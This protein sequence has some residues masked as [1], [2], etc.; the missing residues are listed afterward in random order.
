MNGITHRQAGA[1]AI[2]AV[3]VPFLV[4]LVACEGPAHVSSPASGAVAPAPDALSPYLP[5]AADLQVI[6]QGLHSAVDDCLRSVGLPR[7]TALSVHPSPALQSD[8]S[9]ITISGSLPV[10]RAQQYGYIPVAV[11][12]APLLALD[13]GWAVTY[14]IPR[15]QGSELSITR[16][17]LLGKVARVDGRA[18]PDGGC[19]AKAIE[20]VTG[21]PYSAVQASND[22]DALPLILLR[23][24][25]DQVSRDSPVKAV[26]VR[27]ATCIRQAGYDYAT[28]TA[29]QTDPRWLRVAA[30]GASEKSLIA[31][32]V[33][34]AVADARCRAEVGYASARLAAFT[35]A[36]S[37]LVARD[38][39][40]RALTRF[41]ADVTTAVA[42]ARKLAAR[43]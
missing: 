29:A 1:A 36:L 34:V 3:L 8:T 13:S 33:P 22:I 30:A 38:G 16:A 18:V 23:Q 21:D 35:S 4:F 26:T 2:L 39:I 9:L 41:D 20:Q 12:D 10:A 27:W 32:Q 19:L 37:E 43:S 40:R 28:P 42:R 6:E 17:A 24:A 15:A 11:S 7:P 31:L 5:S 14:R 25:A